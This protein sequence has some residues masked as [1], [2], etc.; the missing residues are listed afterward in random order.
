M[1]DIPADMDSD[2]YYNNPVEV[3]AREYAKEWSPK[4]LQYIDSI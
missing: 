4:Y 1:F 3:A 2:S